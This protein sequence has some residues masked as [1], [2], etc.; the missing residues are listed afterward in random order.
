MSKVRATLDAWR[1]SGDDRFD[2]VRFRVIEAMARRAMA[3]DGEA[4]RVLDEKLVKLIDAYADDLAAHA[5][6]DTVI[7]DSKSGPLAG[8]LDYI[9]SK[10][11]TSSYP[12]MA[13][14]EFFRQTWNT[15]SAEKQ[16]KQ[17]LARVPGNAGPLNSSS[18][19][20]RALSLMRESSPGYL[21]QFLSYADALSWL[22]EL[23]VASGVSADK[24][25]PRGAASNKRLIKKKK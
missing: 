17:S 15:I 6:R 3:H 16:F 9:A 14:L 24:D 25:T 13:A 22:E 19:V 12:E 20:H 8:L 7:G 10:H 2:P 1:E 11:A 18:L 5:M 23:T 4:R 21:Q